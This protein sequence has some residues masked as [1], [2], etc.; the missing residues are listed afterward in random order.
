MEYLNLVD[1]L[2]TIP[3]IAKSAVGVMLRHAD[4]EP[5]VAGKD[6]HLAQL[7]DAGRASAHRLGRELQLYPLAGVYSSVI[8]RCVDTG[9]HLLAGAEID[10]VVIPDATLSS[11]YIEN[12]E[13]AKIEF[14]R[15]DPSRIILDYLSGEQIS[16]F[17]SIADGSRRMLQFMRERM[18]VGKLS[19]F[20]T[21]D[22]LAM[23]FMQHFLGEQFSEEKWFPVLGAIIV[24]ANASGVFVNGR[25]IDGEGQ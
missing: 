14:A 3:N 7:T 13:I 25:C 9:K 10:D 2:Q 17:G 16:G 23:P 24:T 20:V 19:L 21:H 15:R 4:R 18:E 6:A 1:R 5:I 22:A 12:W 11:G 8:E